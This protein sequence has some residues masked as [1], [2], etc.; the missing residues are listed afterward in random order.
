MAG[1]KGRAKYS[2]DSKA[3]V[4][5]PAKMR[6]A[7]NPEAKNTFTI[8][9]GLD[10][11]IFLYP[12]D[13]WEQIEAEVGALNQFDGANRSFMRG[14]LPWAEEVSLDG[15]GRIGLPR[16]LIDF[17]GIDGTVLI[18]GNYDHIEIWDPERFERYLEAEAT[19]YEQLAERVMARKANQ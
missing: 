15:Q 6:S 13:R 12:Q 5:I 18:L 16:D 9:R 8:T 3:R 19:D 11:C 7:M 2:V 1:F 14:F 10:S 17:A 4:A